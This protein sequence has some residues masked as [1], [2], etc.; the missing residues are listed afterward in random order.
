MGLAE[1]VKRVMDAKGL[2]ASEV[3]RKSANRIT[4]GHVKNILSGKTTNP[5]LKVL[6]GLAEGLDVD[7]YEVFGAAAQIPPFKAD[8]GWN[9]H[10]L[11]RVL[12][13]LLNLKQTKIRAVKRLLELE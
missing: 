2:S 7:P 11:V 4:D 9:P 3:E 6:L 1:Y 5:T 12:Q 8:Q 10:D 13:K